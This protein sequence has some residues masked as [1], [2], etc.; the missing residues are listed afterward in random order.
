MSCAETLYPGETHYRVSSTSPY[1][2]T[3]G[4][5]PNDQARKVHAND[6]RV[7][8]ETEHKMAERKAH[9]PSIFDADSDEESE[10]DETYRKFNRDDT[11]PSLLPLNVSLICILRNCCNA[12]M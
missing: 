4:H 6:R 10:Q 3:S 1:S 12:G 7:A 2:F 8:K 9:F 5:F 11:G